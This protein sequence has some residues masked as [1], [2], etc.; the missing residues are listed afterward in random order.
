M[1]NG[2]VISVWGSK[3]CGKTTAAVKI[4]SEFAERKIDTILVLTDI[5]APDINCL[6]PARK[7]LQTM[8]HLWSTPDCSMD[9]IL[10]ACNVTDSKHLAV[11]AFKSGENVF[12]YPEYTKENILDI[13][14][15]LKSLADYII[16]DCVEEF[17][18]NILT[19][20]SLELADKVVRLH[21]PL[22]KSFSFFDSN[23]AL[24]KDSRYKTDQ[25]Y[26]VLAK[27]KRS[28]AKEIAISHF[29]GIQA[30]LPYSEDLENQMLEGELFK[31]AE[32]KAMKEYNEGLNKIIAFIM[33]E[34]IVELTKDKEHDKPLWK[35]SSK[36]EK[37]QKDKKSG[38]NAASD[39]KSV[40]SAFK[41]RKKEV[42]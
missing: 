23:M 25:H 6:M 5:L 2:K 29:G 12:S 11:L 32:G 36:K 42:L 9:T 17:A 21:E 19:M 34:E 35:K 22:M 28:Q 4:A 1:S 24:L 30:E 13:F 27:G 8:G 33:D 26:K 15:K 40:R 41:F 38:K 37:V 31:K 7:D 3:G 39:L 20:V 14:V 10:K 18:F 16:V